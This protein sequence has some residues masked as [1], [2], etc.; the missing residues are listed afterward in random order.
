MISAQCDFRVREYDEIHH[1]KEKAAISFYALTMDV[2]KK[3]I[4][5]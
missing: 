4:N 2:K 3:F 5:K 1:W